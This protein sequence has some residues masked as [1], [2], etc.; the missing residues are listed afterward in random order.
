MP[1]SIENIA[2]YTNID[3]KYNINYML[4]PMEIKVSFARFNRKKGILFHFQ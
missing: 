4:F 3:R 1:N 2:S